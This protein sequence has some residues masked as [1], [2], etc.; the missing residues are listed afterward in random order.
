MP[1]DQ[2]T[3]RDERAAVGSLV[4]AFAHYELFPPLCPDAA[5][6]PRV[7]ELFCRMLFRMSVRAGGVF[8]TAD[9]AAVACALP[10]GK[11]WPG[12]WGYVRSGVLSL[13]WQLGLRNGW[14]FARLGPAFD[15]TREKHM[16]TRP[17]W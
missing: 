6:R 1:I 3:R 7:V 15:A 17:H 2:L 8:A 13:V 16:G 9:R 5:R 11:E 14:W 12:E 10:P 4:A